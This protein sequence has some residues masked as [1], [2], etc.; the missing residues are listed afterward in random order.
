MSGEAGIVG[1]RISLEGAAGVK[2]GLD[3]VKKGVDGLGASHAQAAAGAKL[4]AHQTA[5]LSAQLQ[6]LFVQIQAGGNPLTAMIQQGSQLSAV[7][8]GVGPALKAIGGLITPTTV[9]LGALGGAG[10]LQRPVG[11]I[12]IDLHAQR[13]STAP[14]S[15]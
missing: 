5:Q 8:G 7:F 1:I 6:D 12:H 3:D 9:A 14:H 10:D 11:P 4:N 15:L 2:Q 13:T